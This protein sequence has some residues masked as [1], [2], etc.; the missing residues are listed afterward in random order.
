VLAVLAPALAVAGCSTDAPGQGGGSGA[1]T[2]ASP[3]ASSSTGSTSA[4]T[5]GTTSS[6]P[7]PGSAAGTTQASRVVDKLLVVVVENHSL[8]QMQ[9]AMPYTASLARRYGYATHYTAT[10]HP[11]LPNYLAI[12]SGS[13][14]GVADD[15]PPSAHPVP[16]PTVF[17]A[18]LARGQ[19]AGVYVDGMSSPCE[20]ASAGDYAVKH[21]P[22]P[23]FTAEAAQCRR[24]NLPLPAFG[25]AVRTGTLP[26]AGMLLPDLCHDAHNCPLATADRWF[27]AEMKAIE[28]GPDWRSGRLAVV[29]TAD[30]DDHTAGNRVLTVVAHPSLS[31]VVVT[32]PLTH[33]SLTRLYA[34]VTGTTPL[35]YGASAPSMAT[36]FGLPVR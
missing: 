6:S 36:A 13:T 33:Y 8:V 4:P 9:A 5:G 34:E 23:Y 35:G 21:N 27:E 31:H 24:Y 19:T 1:S 28:A 17:G 20:R 2:S 30:E 29:L 25:T 16:G 32:R 7:S 22:W 10:R 11:S 15:A 12:V 18:A 14:H 26:N 3:T